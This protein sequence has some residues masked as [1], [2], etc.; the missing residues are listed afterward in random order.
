MTKSRKRMLIS[1]I[2]MLLV[3]LVALGSA[4]YAWFTVQKTVTANAMKV[5]VVAES[6]LEISNTKADGDWSSWQK[7]EVSYTDASYSVIP[8]SY[9]P[10]NTNKQSYVPA[11]AVESGGKAYAGTY[12]ASS[13][14]DSVPVPSEGKQQIKS[15][16]FIVYD[17][18]IRSAA[19]ETGSQ[20]VAHSGI[21]ATVKYKTGANEEAEKFI[22]VALF[23][24]DTLKA[25]YGIETGAQ[26][27]NGTAANAKTDV[28]LTSF[29]TAT[30][31]LAN[32]AADNTANTYKLVVWF[33]GNDDDC[34]DTNKGVTGELEVV[35][36]FTD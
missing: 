26:A 2:A 24:S 18:A 23:E 6:G 27:V 3:A 11:E 9:A 22:R 19:A 1:S 28:T 21:T 30:T 4:T 32:T 13:V 17:V 8:I 5:K 36:G 15:G 16:N 29:G 14:Y 35:F 25:T 7:T 12:K 33:E 10:S 20:A 34:K 31:G